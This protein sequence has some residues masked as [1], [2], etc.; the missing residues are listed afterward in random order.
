VPLPN[1]EYAD[2]PIRAWSDRP[3]PAALGPIA[4]HW[5]PRRQWAGTYDAQW[6]RE[7]Q[8]LLPQDFDDRHYQ[9]VPPDQQV[10][11]FLRGGEP[12]ALRHLAAGAADIRFA[13]PRMFLGFE[14]FFD[15]GPN[16]HH[17]PPK[18]HTVILEPDV[19]RVS[20]VWHTALPCHPRVL[21][22]RHTRITLKQDL[23]DRAPAPVTAEA[24]A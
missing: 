9:C 21:K 12:V 14:T 18:L 24:E 2:Q 10:P 15:A 22:L 11:G 16:V 6:Q 20:L 13:L 1:I 3:A 7:R 23:S 19:W 5:P 8:P 17:R 4:C